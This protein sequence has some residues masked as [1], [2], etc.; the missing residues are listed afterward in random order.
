MEGGCDGLAAAH[1]GV[2]VIQAA[3]IKLEQADL[4]DSVVGKAGRLILVEVETGDIETGFVAHDGGNCASPPK[5][6]DIVLRGD[7]NIFN[8]PIPAIDV[9]EVDEISAGEE[10][11]GAKIVIHAGVVLVAAGGV[12][13]AGI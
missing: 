7:A 9:V 2:C 4:G 3:D 1:G 12:R 5:C 10:L 11:V 8:G 6:T 13:D